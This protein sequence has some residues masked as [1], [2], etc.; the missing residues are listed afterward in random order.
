M[1]NL[2]R[3]TLVSSAAAL[4]LLT[5]PVAISASS[6]DPIFA[7]IEEHRAAQSKIHEI[8]G[9]T[10]EL[11]E[12]LPADRCRAYS[13]A[14]RGTDFGVD[15][16]PRW[17]ANQAEY[18]SAEDRSDAIAWSFVE[19]PPTSLA[20]A[21]TLLAY[22]NEH[23]ARGYEWPDRRHSFSADGGYLGHVEEDWRLSMNKALA[24]ALA[25]IA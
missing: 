22:A 11:E 12:M 4:P 1:S 16:D 5:A 10:V 15:D 7:A 13:I 19:H 20:G 21:A 9:R 3:R 18:W 14:H 8:L 25:R 2:S 17:T 23:E 6:P 24:P